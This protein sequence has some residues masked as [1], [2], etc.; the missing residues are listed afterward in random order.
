GA[1]MAYEWLFY[2]TRVRLVKEADGEQLYDGITNDELLEYSAE[3]KDAYTTY[4][5]GL[6]LVDEDGVKLTTD[7]LLDHI[8]AL[9]IA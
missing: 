4:F 7:N 8:K 9:M 1:D 2:D 5:N 3:L 6:G